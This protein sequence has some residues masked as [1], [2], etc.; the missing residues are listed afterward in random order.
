M[1]SLSDF[2]ETWLSSNPTSHNSKDDLNSFSNEQNST[3][4]SNQKNFILKS[5]FFTNSDFSDSHSQPQLFEELK[6]IESPIVF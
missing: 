4:I 6:Y 2:S 1:S 3:K 5:D